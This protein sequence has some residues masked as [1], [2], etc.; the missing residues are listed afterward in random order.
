MSSFIKATAVP[1]AWVSSDL[2]THFYA[3]IGKPISP[4]HWQTK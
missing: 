1:V 4:F 2:L 3:T